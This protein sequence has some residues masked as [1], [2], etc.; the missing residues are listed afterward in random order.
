MDGN[1][2][3]KAFVAALDR[4]GLGAKPTRSWLADYANEGEGHRRRP[5]EDRLSFAYD[6]LENRIKELSEAEEMAAVRPDLNGEEIMAILG[7][8]AGRDVGEAYN[9][10]L[11]VRLDEGPIG[12]DLAR[13]RLLAW[14]ANR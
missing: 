8:P 9:Y 1:V 4:A 3:I 13:E 7:I 10:L 5:G 14:W 6:D 11:N 12:A 2:S